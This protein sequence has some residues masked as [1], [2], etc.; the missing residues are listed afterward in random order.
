MSVF[1]GKTR[2]ELKIIAKEI[3]RANKNYGAEF[4]EIEFR[5][6]L[7]KSLLSAH[8]NRDYLVQVYKQ[9]DWTRL[10][11]CRTG[12]DPETNRWFDGI[13]WDTLMKIKSAVGYGDRDAVEIYPK[14]DNVVNVA[15]IR[16]LFILPFDHKLDCIWEKTGE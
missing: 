12:F 6:E 13:S 7:N 16:H 5:E 11:I 8:K 2:K 15:N 3:E 10:S 1:P 14:D 4:V 9:G